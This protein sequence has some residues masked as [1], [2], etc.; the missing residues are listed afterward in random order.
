MQNND[1]NIHANHRSRLKSKFLT[2]GINAIA[3]HEIMELLLFFAIKR[4]DVNPLAHSLVAKFGSVSGVLNASKEDLMKVG[5]IGEK[6]ASF[7]S[8]CGKSIEE[9]LQNK[10]LTKKL[11][12]T[13]IAKSFASKTIKVNSLEEIYIICLDG[14]F[15]IV[16]TTLLASGDETKIKLDI[17]KL[18]D[19]VLKAKVPKIILVH[20]HPSGKP[21][22]SEKDIVFTHS[23]VTSCLFN[24]IDIVDHIIVAPSSSYS[25]AEQNLLQKI[26]MSAYNDIPGIKKINTLAS[27]NSSGYTNSAS[28]NASN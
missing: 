3:E 5:G 6:T 17:N 25:F 15:G 7:I 20:T 22:P 1:N 16:S 11:T 24:D 8:S 2:Y 9:Y 4:K 19:F 27:F 13:E 14:L 28:C 10:S 26:K 12:S 21:L 18:T 23:L